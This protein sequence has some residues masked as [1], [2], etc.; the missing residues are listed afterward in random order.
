MQC[1][2][3]AAI[4]PLLPKGPIWNLTV[5]G[6]GLAMCINVFRKNRLELIVLPT[7]SKLGVFR[8]NRVIMD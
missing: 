4:A 5:P 3:I 8:F 7:R 1:S 2:S 6:R